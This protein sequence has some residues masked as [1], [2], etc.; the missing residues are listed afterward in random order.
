MKTKNA[1]Q[2]KAKIKKMANDMN[3]SAQLVLQNYMLE[4]LIERIS[5]STYKDQVIIKGGMLIGS[6]IGIDKR[7]TMDLDTTIKGFPLT[8]ESASK[9]FKEICSI[10]LDEGIEFEFLRTEYIRESDDYS[11]IRAY[12]KANYQPMSIPLVVDITT[13]DKITPHEIE[14]SYPLRFDDGDIQILAYPLETILAEKIETVLSRGIANTRPR[15]YYD[16]Y[17]LWHLRKDACSFKTLKTALLATAEKRGSTQSINDYQTI[18][19]RVLADSQMQA[20]WE[21]YA[22]RFSYAQG[23][24]FGDACNTVDEIIQQIEM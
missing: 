10:K 22:K 15:D 13:G 20:H 14:Y 6:L 4:R 17:M 1:M 11:G 19:S 7:T 24:S 12:L 9:V 23:I 3:V 2:L 8:H 5:L 16:I 21:S 18:L